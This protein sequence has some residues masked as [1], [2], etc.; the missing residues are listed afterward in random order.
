MQ[1]QFHVPRTLAKID[2]FT[3]RAEKH[4]QENKPAGTLKITVAMHAS[5][6]DTL[7]AGFRRFLFRRPSAGEQQ[8]LI[9]GDNLTELALPHLAPLRYG[10]KFPGY[11]LTIE[12]GLELSKPMILDGVELS[13]LQIEPIKGGSV[14][15]SFNAACHP[16]GEE[17]FGALCQLIQNKAEI[18]L[19]P[20]TPDEA[21][22]MAMGGEGDTL[23][24]QE[25]QD[26]EADAELAAAEARR[27][28]EIGEEADAA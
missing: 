23:D 10:E 2:S 11:T 16:D 8:Q 3:P 17:Q 25:E 9:D 4:G 21:P 18:T 15:L 5:A 22:Q 26:A 12:T 24:Q 20:P 14:K 7:D 28:A 6:L 27:L 19:T 13:A 1:Q